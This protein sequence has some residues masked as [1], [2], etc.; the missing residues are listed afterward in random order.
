MKAL[1][2]GAIEESGLAVR[3]LGLSKNFGRTRALVDCN[4]DLPVGRFMAL[5]GPNGAGKSTL[6]NLLVGLLAP[7]S[8]QVSICARDP[9]KERRKVLQLIGF[10]AQ[11]RPLYRN[12][13]V[14]DTLELGRRFSPA[15]DREL[16]AARIE[17]LAIPINSEVGALSG[18]Q[19]AQISL[20]LALGK[21][22]G[23]LILDE[24]MASLDPVARHDFLAEVVAAA[25]ERTITVIM[26]SHVLAE[27]GRVCN[28]LAILREGHLLVSGSI[29]DILESSKTGTADPGGRAKA[30]MTDLEQIVMSYLMEPK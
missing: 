6:L 26:S 25:E 30:W 7:T 19:Q 18:G 12:L 2:M 20:T 22:P 5:V 23:L 29:P 4:L 14:A 1:P 8:G 24:P 21:R 16:A 3:A 27:L 28:Y 13:T 9:R 10:V 15:W 11:D 17:R